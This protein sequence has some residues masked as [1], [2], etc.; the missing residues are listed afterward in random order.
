[1]KGGENLRGSKA[2]LSLLPPSPNKTYSVACM[3]P[4]FGEGVRGYGFKNF[5]NFLIYQL[6]ILDIGIDKINIIYYNMLK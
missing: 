1:L 5:L 4:L 6:K 2:P 3:K